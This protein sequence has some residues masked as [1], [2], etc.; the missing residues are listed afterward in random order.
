MKISVNIFIRINSNKSFTRTEREYVDTVDLVILACLNFREFLILG[1][2]A[3]FRIRE[4]LFFFNNAILIIIFA[5]F[6][7]SR[8]CSTREIRE[9]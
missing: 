6:L 2:F 3:K 9:N 7:N 5:R 4:F 1:L 8:I